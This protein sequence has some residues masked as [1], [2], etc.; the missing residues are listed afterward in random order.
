MRRAWTGILWF[1]LAAAAHADSALMEAEVLETSREVR[2]AG[3]APVRFLLLHHKHPKDQARMS[4]WLH[5]HD[6]SRIEF[7]TRDGG[8]HTAA[9]YRLKH[10]FG[11]GLLLYSDTV[12]IEAKDVIALRLD[13]G[14]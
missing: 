12:V 10:C 8:V 7:R 14:Q 5:R 2:L 3:L 4:E 13:A 11:R 6:G 9:L 1:G